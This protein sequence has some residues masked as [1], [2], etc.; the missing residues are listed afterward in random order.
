MLGVDSYSVQNS[1]LDR[2][3]S[4]QGNSL[5]LGP[6]SSKALP[7]SLLREAPSVSLQQ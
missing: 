1:A 3:I 2:N 4:S 6:V 7:S 5:L